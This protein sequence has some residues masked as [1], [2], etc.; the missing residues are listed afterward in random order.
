V[1][2][3]PKLFHMPTVRR[4][5]FCEVCGRSWFRIGAYKITQGAP[6]CYHVATFF[7]D[8]HPQVMVRERWGRE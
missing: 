3:L 5:W 4:R 2:W 6:R 7:Q 8:E 1:N